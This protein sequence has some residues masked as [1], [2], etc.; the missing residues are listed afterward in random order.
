MTLC[1]DVLGVQ[2]SEENVGFSTP[3]SNPN[4]IYKQTNYHWRL[5]FRYITHYVQ[6]LTLYQKIEREKNSKRIKNYVEIIKTRDNHKVKDL[7]VSI[8][9]DKSNKQLFTRKIQKMGVDVLGWVQAANPPDFD[10]PRKE[11]PRR[12]LSEAYSVSFLCSN[13]FCI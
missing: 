11:N 12:K 7:T 4:T 9:K 10:L 13:V 5:L 1:L 6:K 8:K 2:G 3:Y